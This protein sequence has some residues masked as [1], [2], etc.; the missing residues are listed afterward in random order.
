MPS[1]AVAQLVEQRTENPWVGGSNP[2]GGTILFLAP[3]LRSVSRCL[4]GLLFLLT[5][6]LAQRLAPGDRIRLICEQE[7]TLSVERVISPDGD[8][9]LPLLGRVALAGKLIAEAEFE[10]AQMATQ[11]LR[12]DVVRIAITVVNDASADIE[13]SGAVKRSGSVPWHS[14]ITLDDISKLAEPTGSAEI[15]AVVITGAEGKR[16]VVDLRTA[17]STTLRPGDRVVFPQAQGANEVYVVGGVLRPGSKVFTPGMTA[18]SLIELAGGL[19][20]HGIAS[21]ITLVRKGEAPKLIELDGPS[22]EE[23]LQRGDSVTVAVIEKGR[24][25]TVTGFVT[26]QGVVEYRDGM[27][28][29][30]AIKGAGGRSTLAG[31]AVTVKRVG[32]WKHAFDLDLIASGKSSDPVLQPTDMVNVEMAPKKKP[33]PQPQPKRK[34]GSHPVVPPR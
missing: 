8:V 11:K 15:E 27:T 20:G 23:L 30:E 5:I 3:T 7:P 34:P 2:P 1:A 9:V 13:F 6:A 31:A 12:L 10:I 22:A 19:S 24:F 28:L 25:I 26:R 21:K 18:R 14:G 4:I 29:I 17:G 33:A 16:I 32:G